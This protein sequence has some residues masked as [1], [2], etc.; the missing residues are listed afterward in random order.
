[1]RRTAILLAVTLLASVFLAG[2]AGAGV[3][4]HT[5]NAKGIG[6]DVGGFATIAQIQGGGLLQGTTAAQFVPGDLNDTELAFT[7]PIVFTTNRAT[8]TVSLSGT[9]DLVSGFFAATGPVVGAT[10][11]LAGAEGTLAFEGV[12]DFATG[13]F[14][15]TVRGEIC[16]DLAANGTS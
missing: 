3:S 5:I 12:Q 9:F 1:M 14:T 2:P 8:L 7:G 16:V 6:Q 4:C 10:G 13:S 15:E 11:K